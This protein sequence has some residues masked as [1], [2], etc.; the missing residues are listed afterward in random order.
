H[1]HKLAGKPKVSNMTKQIQSV[2]LELPNVIKSIRKRPDS[3]RNEAVL[4]CYGPIV[5]GGVLK[6]ALN[7][8]RGTLL[9]WYKPGSRKLNVKHVY[10][11]RRL[12][13]GGKLEYRWE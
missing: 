5:E 2:P 4:A 3:L 11:I 1:R 10:L 7:K 6:L 13:L 9:V 12:G 8:Q